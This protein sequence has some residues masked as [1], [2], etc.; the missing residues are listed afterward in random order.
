MSLL[1]SHFQNTQIS[2]ADYYAV[3]ARALAHA[4]KCLRNQYGADLSLTLINHD[5]VQA[6]N[7]EWKPYISSSAFLSQRYYYGDWLKK[8]IIPASGQAHD[9]DVIISPN[10]YPW[11]F[12]AAIWH[13]HEL[14]GLSIGGY[15]E[16][17][18]RDFVSIWLIEASPHKGHPLKGK[19]MEIVD[20]AS[21]FYA[22]ELGVSKVCHMGPFSEG[23]QKNYRVMGLKGGIV[24]YND[25]N[26]TA[27]YLRDVKTTTA[28][29]P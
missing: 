11:R 22:T 4:Q 26:N 2:N 29:V 13:G 5:A 18:Q 24:Q 10:F 21:A 8:F 23:A 28:P 12:E 1:Q 9:I 14:C 25:R 3:K 19:I 17:L 16:E 27:A 7:A 20:L 15:K 6:R